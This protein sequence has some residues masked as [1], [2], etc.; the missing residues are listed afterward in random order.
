MTSHPSAWNWITAALWVVAVIWYAYSAVT[1][2]RTRHA[3]PK[4]H[5]PPTD[6][7]AQEVQRIV[8]NVPD[9]IPAVK[10]LRESHPGQTFKDAVD[11]ID[12]ARDTMRPGAG[13]RVGDSPTH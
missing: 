4:V 2:W 7:P 13:P 5:L 12:A 3:P 10:A 9:R 6:V 8:H 11:F 1:T